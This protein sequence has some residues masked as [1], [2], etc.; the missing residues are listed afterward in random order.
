MD[1]GLY[2]PPDDGDCGLSIVAPRI[3]ALD[4]GPSH[5]GLYISAM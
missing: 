5:E 3:Y 2:V 1:K 4:V